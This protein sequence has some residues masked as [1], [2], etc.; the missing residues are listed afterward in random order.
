MKP[1]EI[2]KKNN[3]NNITMETSQTFPGPVNGEITWLPILK[4]SFPNTVFSNIVN[5]ENV[6]FN[7]DFSKPVA[8]WLGLELN[9]RHHMKAISHKCG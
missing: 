2:T 3:N 9:K 7:R 5:S 8:L 1:F 4:R 6:T